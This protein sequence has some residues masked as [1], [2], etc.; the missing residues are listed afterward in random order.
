[1]FALSDFLFSEI[2]SLLVYKNPPEYRTLRAGMMASG[3]QRE[4]IPFN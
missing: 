1:M 2:E 3:V 4:A